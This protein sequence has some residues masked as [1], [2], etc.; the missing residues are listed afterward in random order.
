MAIYDPLYLGGIVRFN[1]GEYFESHEVW[2]DLW[3]ATRG[4]A[5]LFYKGL[6]QAAVSLYHTRRGNPRGAEKLFSRSCRALEAYRPCY[7]GLNVERFL[8]ELADCLHG[9]ESSAA[10]RLSKAPQIELSPPENGL[11]DASTQPILEQ[12]SLP[13]PKS[14]P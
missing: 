4:P 9:R 5:R 11:P 10:E 8:V 12:R 2:E 6:I 14:P 13:R 7:L 1:R 3:R